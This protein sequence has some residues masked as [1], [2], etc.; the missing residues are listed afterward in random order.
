[1][2]EDNSSR[3]AANANQLYWHTTRPAGRLADELGISRSKFYALIEPLRLQIECAT[4]GT[5]LAFN[6]RSDREAGRGQCPSCGAVAHVPEAPETVFAPTAY[7]PPPP[8]GVR[9]WLVL[10]GTRELWVS[11]IAGAAAGLLISGWW[12][13]R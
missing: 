7:H 6:S 9:Q 2:S 3:L 11:A 1:M 4:C 13:R 8:A 5:P 10:P 12:R